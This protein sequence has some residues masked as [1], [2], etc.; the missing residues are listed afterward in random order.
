MRILMGVFGFSSAIVSGVGWL[1]ARLIHYL[2]KSVESIAGWGLEQI[3][4]MP[5]N[6]QLPIYVTFGILFVGLLMA[7][8]WLF[9]HIVITT[10]IIVP[11]SIFL[12][13]LFIGW[14]VLFVLGYAFYSVIKKISIRFIEY[15]RN[16][17]IG[18]TNYIESSEN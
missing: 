11:I 15:I 3:Q 16:I 2:L 12:L 5:E 1:F 18:K 6:I 4:S 8:I 14:I 13:K 10:L 9:P 7:A 17:H